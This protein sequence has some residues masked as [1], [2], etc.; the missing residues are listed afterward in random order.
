ML[1]CFVNFYHPLSDTCQFAFTFEIIAGE[2]FW[3]MLFV[4]YLVYFPCSVI[5]FIDQ[6]YSVDVGMAPTWACKRI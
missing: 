1:Q 2:L 6:M 3:K 5:L 4:V